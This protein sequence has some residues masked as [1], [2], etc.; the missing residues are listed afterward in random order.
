IRIENPTGSPSEVVEN[1]HAGQPAVNVED[2]CR[3][4]SVLYAA[5][6]TSG[7]HR[8][9]GGTWEHWSD[10]RA[11]RVWAVKRRILAA[12]SNGQLYE[13]RSG[14]GGSVLLHTLEPGS[15]WTA[16]VDGGS[17]ILA[18][19]DD[20]YV[21]AFAVGEDG[22]LRLVGESEFVDEAPVGMGA[23]EGIVL[24]GTEQRNPAGGSIGRLWRAAVSPAGLLVSRQL[25]RE[26]GDTSSPI[27]FGPRWML[28][29]R[30]EIFTVVRED[31]NETH[32]WR[33]MLATG[34]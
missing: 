22:T 15:A 20:G 24:V 12:T 7:I 27:N 13:P 1:P 33:Y 2:L 34:G 11:V 30:D 4:G 16:V 28:V 29:D 23:Y 6:G 8:R 25:L 32:L 10:I 26:W 3:L 9:V 17:H 31:D 19:A 21:Y 5:L 18:A 14:S